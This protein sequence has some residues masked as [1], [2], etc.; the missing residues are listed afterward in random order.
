MLPTHETI[1]A[2]ARTTGKL[3]PFTAKTRAAL[4][5]E[6]RPIAEEAL[7]LGG[8]TVEALEI[9]ARK[10][11]QP[12]RLPGVW[13]T[14]YN[15]TGTEEQHTVA[16]RHLKNHGIFFGFTK[17]EEGGFRTTALMYPYGA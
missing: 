3:P 4:E 13:V 14:F 2:K 8:F 12:R 1:L 15:F 9:V 10:S 7:K 6:A 17:R 5:A 11:S 16:A